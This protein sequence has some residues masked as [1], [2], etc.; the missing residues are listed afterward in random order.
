MPITLIQSNLSRGN[1]VFFINDQE[2]NGVQ[3]VSMSYV[4]NISPVKYLGMSNSSMVMRGVQPATV[5]VAASVLTYDQ[6]ISFTGAS[7]VKGAVYEPSNTTKG[8]AFTEG[9]LTNYS[10]NYS[11]GSLPEIAAAFTCL[12]DMGNVPREDIRVNT[13]NIFDQSS[14]P[15]YIP[16]PGCLSINLD[17]FNTNRLLGYNIAFSINR[18]PVFSAG[19]R[20]PI[21]VLNAIPINV[22]C[23]FQ[24]DVND[25]SAYRQTHFPANP[26]VRQASLSLRDYKTQIEVLSYNFSSLVLDG[27][28]YD[29]N[30]EGNTSITAIYKGFLV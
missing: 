27:E 25:Y 13:D 17:E 26:T 2:I 30:Q 8:F 22:T 11:L 5:S 20:S 29:T 12:G 19:Q 7:A 24:F 4:N 9:Y 18:T 10:S 21:A 3:N 1:Q 14:R 23:S 15:L 16:G 6:F 28:T